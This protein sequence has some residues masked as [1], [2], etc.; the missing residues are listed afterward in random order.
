MIRVF[1][2]VSIAVISLTGINASAE[3]EGSVFG[4]WMSAS[5]RGVI[6]IYHCADKLCG[7]I[8]WLKLINR[9]GEPVRDIK[10]SDP[11]LQQRP[12]CGMNMLGNF[13]EI[14]ET[15]WE[16]G[17]IYNPEDGE[18]YSAKISLENANTLKLRGYI[19]ISLLGETQTW[20][21]AP[22]PLGPCDNSNASHASNQ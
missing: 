10:N 14:D 16:G 6:E 8:V 22:S 5:G 12:L 11:K 3:T 4:R 21:R 17:W 20:S 1:A 15:H 7:R 18:T 9:D 19:G 2:A 13:Q